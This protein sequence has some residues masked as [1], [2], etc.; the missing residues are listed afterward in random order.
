M[1]HA[2]VLAILPQVY[3]TYIRPRYESFGWSGTL[4]L[5]IKNGSV[6][7]SYRADDGSLVTKWVTGKSDGTHIWLNIPT[8]GG[9]RVDGTIKNGAIDGYAT[10]L[11][12]PGPYVFTATPDATQ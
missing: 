8:L 9:L 2:L 4:T 6:T 1:L 5:Y 7:G 11:K 10:S 3:H 12:K